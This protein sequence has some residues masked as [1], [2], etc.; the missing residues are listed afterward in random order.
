MNKLKRAVVKEELVAL[1][2]DY[3]DAIILNQFIYWSERT[4]DFDKFID[5]EK[6]RYQNEGID[7][8][9]NPTNGWMYKKAEEL[10][11]ET[12]V[13]LAPANMRNRIKK[14]ID[15]EWIE[16]RRNPYIKWDK[17]LQYRVNLI[18]IAKDL[19]DLGYILQD[20]KVNISE[21]TNRKLECYE[22]KNRIHES[23]IPNNES[24]IQIHESK[25]HYQRLLLETTIK[26]QLVSSSGEPEE[27]IT[28]ELTNIF[29]Q[30]K[31]DIYED[32]SLRANIK[33]SIKELYLDTASR[34]TV[35]KIDLYNIDEAISRYREAQEQ[36]AIKNPKLYFKKCLLSAIE[37]G[38]LT[39]IV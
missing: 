16:E 10:S 6:K 34:E 36:K 7:I 27:N 37:E 31:V 3:T 39:N 25:Q 29:N 19:F 18:K 26:N 17:T 14:L 5:E 22:T 38:G 23:K 20:Y 9:I 4:K 32:E 33:E 8:T 24:K 15:K 12:M 21:F 13:N 28:D 11:E 30:S 2:C 1:T 35:K